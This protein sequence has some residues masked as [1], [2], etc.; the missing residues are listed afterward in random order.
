MTI[1]IIMMTTMIM[2]NYSDC[3][4]CCYRQYNHDCYQY[5]HRL[6]LCDHWTIVVVNIHYCRSSY[7]CYYQFHFCY[8][9]QHHHHH[10]CS[11]YNRYD[12]CCMLGSGPCCHPQTEI[13]REV[14]DVVRLCLQRHGISG[15][16][17]RIE[18]I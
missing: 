11:C 16:T 2:E 13:S 14:S 8:C 18:F 4:R 5:C 10:S 17:T 9:Y 15:L 7:S 3:C 12:N 6:L 1:M